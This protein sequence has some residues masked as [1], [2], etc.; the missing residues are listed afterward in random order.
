MKTKYDSWKEV[1]DG[2]RSGEID[3][4]EWVVVMDND[5]SSLSYKGALEEP[6]HELE[7][8]G[9]GYRDIVEVLNAC[10]IPAEWC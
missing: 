1:I 9:N 7:F 8:K 3:S 5:C 4:D 6:E 10:G 2:F